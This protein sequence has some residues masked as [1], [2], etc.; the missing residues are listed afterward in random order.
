[1]IRV[2]ARIPLDH[3][4]I[5]LRIL[6]HIQ[7]LIPGSD[8]RKR[9]LNNSPV[10]AVGLPNIEYRKHRGAGFQGQQG[11]AD[12]RAGQFTENNSQKPLPARRHSGPEGSP[13]LSPLLKRRRSRP[14]DFCLGTRFVSRPGTQVF[15]KAVGKGIIQGPDD[16]VTGPVREAGEKMRPSTP[17]CRSGP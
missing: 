3:G 17:S 4:R 16:N 9:G 1:M 5:L 2:I 10:A 12:I 6:L 8:E 7:V 14:M 15:H 13:G 11:K